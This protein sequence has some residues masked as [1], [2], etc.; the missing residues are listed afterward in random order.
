MFGTNIISPVLPVGPA[1]G[2]KL[3]VQSIFYTLQGEGPFAGTPCVFVRLAGCN[4]RCSFCDTE[5][6]SGLSQV[7]GVDA[8]VQRVNELRQSSTL[9][10]LTG[11]E[12]FRQNVA[13][14]LCVLEASGTKC[15]QAETAGTVDVSPYLYDLQ[16]GFLVLVCSPKTPQVHASVRRWCGHFKYIIQTGQVDQDGLPS[17]VSHGVGESAKTMRVFKATEIAL[18]K[19]VI[20]VSPCDAHDTAVTAENTRLATRLALQHGY[21]LSL[22]L[23]KMLGLE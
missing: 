16:S 4:L 14:L 17:Y 2:D 1:D 15:V 23:H 12:P 10:V 11:G 21:R 7:M 5:F 22:Q 6:D 8:V 9:V 13:R 19:P 3:Q 18:Q 20:W